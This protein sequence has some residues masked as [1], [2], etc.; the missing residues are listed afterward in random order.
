MT[1]VM[2]SNY[3][4][5]VQTHFIGLTERRIAAMRLAIRLF[6]I[7]HEGKYP[8]TLSELVPMYLPALPTDP[9]AADDKTFGY[10]ASPIPFLYSVGI[11]GKDEGGNTMLAKPNLVPNGDPG[12]PAD[13]RTWDRADVIFRL[14]KYIAPPPT[15]NSD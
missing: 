10:R 4:R 8:Q 6:Q 2:L 12:T 13:N 1:A 7:D 3:E 15:T 5:F 9:F 14:D 11:N